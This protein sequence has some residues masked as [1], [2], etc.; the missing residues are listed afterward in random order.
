MSGRDCRAAAD[1]L[2]TSFEGLPD[3]ESRY[4]RV[5]ALGQE[6]PELDPVLKTTDRFLIEGCVSRAWLVPGRAGTSMT[7]QGDSESSIVKGILALLIRVY[8]GALPEQVLAC[9]PEFLG[10]I[11]LTEHLSMNRRNGLSQVIKQIKL[12]AAV[13]LAQDRAASAE[14]HPD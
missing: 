4:R 1:E 9:E 13:F 12:Y 14:S 6:L 11:G 10:R 8:S 2:A 7:L 3:W 5:I